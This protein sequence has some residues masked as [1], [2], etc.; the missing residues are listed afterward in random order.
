MRRAPET[1][2]NYVNYGGD[3]TFAAS[4]LQMRRENDA[5]SA[6]Q[7]SSTTKRNY[8]IT[9]GKAAKCKKGPSQDEAVAAAAPSA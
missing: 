2:T 8:R 4:L 6:E 7:R 9:N 3:T 5:K 1:L